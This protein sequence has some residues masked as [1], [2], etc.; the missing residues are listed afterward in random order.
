MSLECPRLRALATM[1]LF[2]VLAGTPLAH[3]ARTPARNPRLSAATGPL[4]ESSRPLPGGELS[5]TAASRGAVLDPERTGAAIEAALDSAARLA[6]VF[7]ADGDGELARLNASAARE[8]F[9]CSAELYAALDAALTVAV[10][11][12][13]AYDPTAGPLAR[14]WRTAD[15]GRAP[16][17][18][19][20][21][22]TRQLVGW[23]L[24]LLEPGG[25]TV[26]FRRPGMELALDAVAGGCLLQRTAAVL[27][28]HGI[29][30]ARLELPGEVMTFTNHEAWSVAVPHPDAERGIAMRLRVSNAAVATAG[31]TGGHA[32][33]D[34][35]T[36][37]GVFGDASVTVVSSPAPGAPALAAG[38]LVLGRD[39][40]ADYAHRH[41]DV[42]VLWLE[43]ASDGVRAWVWNLTAFTAEPG[44]RV[45][46]QDA[47]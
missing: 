29:A 13:G 17:D 18:L 12:D 28:E 5:V 15:G 25:R 1:L 42:G 40:A 30:R 4:L 11:T 8:R 21:A 38:L 47:P 35:R 2:A 24:L 22:D 9:A 39:G 31:G 23:R 45:E 27:R 44:L 19:G 34:P 36:G 32:V 33:F 46:W 14:L 37:R 41:T 43:P 6:A 7:A 20:L 3:A 16:G 10:E 26:R